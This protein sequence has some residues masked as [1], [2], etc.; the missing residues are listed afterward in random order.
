MSNAHQPKPKKLT[1]TASLWQQRIQDWEASGL[2]QI[3]F[4]RQHNLNYESFKKWRQ[5]LPADPSSSQRLRLVPIATSANQHVAATAVDH[6]KPLT[7]HIG[8]LRLDVPQGFDPN[9][10]VQVVRTLQGV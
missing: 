3:T 10:L 4:C 2:T 9:L 7:V 6:P 1:A 8:D 5:R